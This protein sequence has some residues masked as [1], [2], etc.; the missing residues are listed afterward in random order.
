MVI[1]VDVVI[2]MVVTVVDVV[3]RTVWTKTSQRSSGRQNSAPCCSC[4]VAVPLLLLSLLV[5]VS[6]TALQVKSLGIR[7]KARRHGL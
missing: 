4:G 5:A 6:L 2:V 3:N 7:F 1:I